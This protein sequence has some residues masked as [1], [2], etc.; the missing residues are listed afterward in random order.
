[1]NIAISCGVKASVQLR[2]CVS[3]DKGEVYISVHVPRSNDE[4][5]A[6]EVVLSKLVI[7]ASLAELS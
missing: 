4:D 5:E 7:I 1:M 6:H 3:S 2:V